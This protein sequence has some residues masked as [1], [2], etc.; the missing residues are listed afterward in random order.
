MGILGYLKKKRFRERGI[1]ARAKVL[2]KESIGSYRRRDYY[3]TVLYETE[4][5]PFQREVQVSS[6]VMN[7]AIRNGEV[8]VVYLP[9]KPDV[10]LAEYDIYNGR[11]FLVTI[12]GGVLLCLISIMR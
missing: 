1:R 9:E 12:F 11:S 6:A 10:P 8:D 3:L 5:G 4:N 2:R 7:E